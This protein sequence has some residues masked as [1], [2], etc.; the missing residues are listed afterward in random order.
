MPDTERTIAEMGNVR[1]LGR[2]PRLDPL[3]RAGLA[4][5]FATNFRVEDFL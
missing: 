1:R 3:T 5:A 2:L 4:E